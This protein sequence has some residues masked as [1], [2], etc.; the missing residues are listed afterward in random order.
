MGL[1]AVSGSKIFIGRR[2]AVPDRDLIDLDFFDAPWVEIKGWAMA[3]TLGDAQEVVSQSLLGRARTVKSKGTRN[4]GRMDN[5]FIPMPNDLGQQRFAKAVANCSA[6]EFKI[7]WNAGCA[8]ADPDARQADLFYGLAFPG[9]K[10]GGEANAAQTRAWSIEV[11]TNIVEQ[12]GPDVPP[13]SLLSPLDNRI[14]LSPIDGRILL[15]A[16]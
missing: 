6:Y 11:V 3:G 8:E 16:A 2:V 15:K 12:S 13:G 7:E 10:Q 1:F 9:P 4:A 14:L 5:T